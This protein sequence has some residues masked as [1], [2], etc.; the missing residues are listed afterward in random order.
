MKKIM[1]SVIIPCYNGEKYIQKCLN[2][3]F[4]QAYKNLEIIIVNDGST[5]SSENIILE[6]QSKFEKK[7][8][9]YVYVKKQ[10]GGLGSAINLG[11][12]KVT[13]DYF[14][15]C[16]DD[17]FFHKDY[18]VKHINF[19]KQNKD[20]KILRC[21]RYDI[22]ESDV[23]YVHKKKDF[24]KISDTNTN[25]Y[26]KKLFM[27]AILEKNFH[28]GCALIK[29]TAFDEIIKDREIYESR[30]GQNWQLL[31]PVLYKYDAYYINEA[32]FY[33]TY[34]SDS[35]SNEYY[36]SKDGRI[37]AMNNEHKNILLNTIKKIEIPKIEKDYLM[38]L[39][40]QK[41]IIKN[42]EEAKLLN[43]KIEIDM[44]ERE[45]LKDVLYDNIYNVEIEK[46]LAKRPLISIIIPV[47][48]GSNYMKEA[49][50][51]ALSQTYKNIEIIVVN[52]GSN[53]DGETAE[54]AKS[55]GNKIK[56]FEK[57]NGGV[58]TALN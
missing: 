50:D 14:T 32:L 52:D 58:A 16:D 27:N 23:N 41:Y 19:L 35:L 55:Y 39:I 26:D 7:G 57:E 49:I 54:I 5:D 38:K 30:L 24:V 6:N 1:I 40:N 43:N 15:W 28:F 3:I 2:S 56:Y 36:N 48:N 13:G 9:R 20:C 18:F 21:D 47:Y 17:N 34:R 37:Y 8:F 12:K 51:S 29:T 10:N 53:D 4:F 33:Y 22:S 44:F 25:I 46:V 45:Y 11:L 31:L 42:L